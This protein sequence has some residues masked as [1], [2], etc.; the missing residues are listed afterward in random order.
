[1]SGNKIEPVQTT[2][3]A[4]VD[5]STL[6]AGYDPQT[7]L[8]DPRRELYCHEIIAQGGNKKR[9]YELAYLAGVPLPKSKANYPYIYFKGPQIRA[10]YDVL[11]NQHLDSVGLDTK[12]ML[13]KSAKLLQQATKDNDI[14]GFTTMVATIMKIRGT[15]IKKVMTVSKKMEV[16]AEDL[17]TIEGIFENL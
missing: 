14:Q 6:I 13:V 15:D 4:P 1:M 3:L 10:R 12:S 7:P 5:P 2:E 11:V 9:A 17:E 16:T 8:K